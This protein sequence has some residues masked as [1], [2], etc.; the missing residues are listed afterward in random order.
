MGGIPI[1]GANSDLP[2]R[3]APN[4]GAVPGDRIVGIMTPGE[5][6]TIYPIES[7]A[8]QDYEDVPERWLDVRWDV[9]EGGMPQRF[10]ARLALQSV[11]EPGTLAQVAQVI[12]EHDGNIDNVRMVRRAKDFTEIQIE[13]EVWDLDH[14]TQIVG[15]LKGKAVVSNVERMF[16]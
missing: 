3:F 12:A 14:L 2:V 7:T 6:I 16:G 5:G 13:L 9:D 8:L 15:G 11:N 4:G 10:P 1:R